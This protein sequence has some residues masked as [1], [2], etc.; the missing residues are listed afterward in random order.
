MSERRDR[1]AVLEQSGGATPSRWRRFIAAWGA[2]RWVSLLLLAPGI[3]LFIF[4]ARQDEP[5]L[6]TGPALLIDN[7]LRTASLLAAGSLAVLVIAREDI[8][9]KASATASVSVL[10]L[11]G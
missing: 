3:A 8:A 6:S 10:A 11:G 1:S 7:L 4:F 2:W 5:A 9:R